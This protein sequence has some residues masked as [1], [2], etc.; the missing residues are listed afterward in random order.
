MVSVTVTI[1]TRNGGDVLRRTLE[2]YMA[3]STPSWAWQL[4]IVDNA[5]DDN[6]TASIISEYKENLPIVH[7]TQAIPGKNASLNFAISYLKGQYTIFSDD[8]AVPGEDFIDQWIKAFS[9]NPEAD[10]MGGEIVP[11]FDKELPNW[12]MSRKLKFEE[13]YA[14]REGL[15]E[16][17][18]EP[19]GIYGPNMAVRN[20]LFA[21][22]HRFE[23]SVGPNAREPFY[24]MGS[25]TEFCV[26]MAGLGY[27]LAFVAGPKVQHIVRSHQ[28]SEQFV[29][30]RAQRL[31]IG[32][33]RSNWNQGVYR[34]RKQGRLWKRIRWAKNAAGLVVQQL[35]CLEPVPSGRFLARWE[36]HF[37]RAYLRE[38]DRLEES[39]LN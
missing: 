1:A 18:I 33:A 3:L 36:Y 30:Q 2:G 25:E 13:L 4:V 34:N 35:R 5:S 15:A 10:I 27:H 32:T 9:R 14:R 38:I 37:R 17:P 11:V 6:L 8:D 31:G 19:T 21:Q 26:R 29:V 16:G 12:L 22:G 23:E 7:L 28:V 20:A 39:S 24:A